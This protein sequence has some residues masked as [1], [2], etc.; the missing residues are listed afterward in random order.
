MATI[1]RPPHHNKL[2]FYRLGDSKHYDH[3]IDY[4]SHHSHTDNHN[5]THHMMDY[6]HRP[7]PLP[8]PL[9]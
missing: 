3:H 6:Y 4:R 1:N 2:A 5:Q 9:G 8:Q 7:V